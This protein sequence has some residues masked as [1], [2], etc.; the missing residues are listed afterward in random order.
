MLRLLSGGLWLALLAGACSLDD[1]SLSDAKLL[2]SSQTQSALECG[3]SGDN[4]CETCLYAECCEQAQSC[5]VG[6]ACAS[7]LSCAT[8]C[9]SSASCLDACASQYPTGLGDAV[10]LGVCASSQCSVCSGQAASTLT[11]DP[12]GPGACQSSA[13]CT[14]LQAGALRDLDP[15]A[16]AAC[17]SDLGGTDCQRC[18][19]R[20]TGLSV[21]CSSCVAVWLACAVDNC[22][23]ACQGGS[24]PEGCEQ[25]MNDAGCTEQLRSCGFSG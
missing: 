1:R 4:G 20:Q 3:S 21:G 7:Y 10:A 25:C 9:N 24:D 6:S 16:C 13:D 5:G 12:T 19:S 2:R 15:S 14:A 17:Q 23:I 11:C 22:L 8:G 18:L